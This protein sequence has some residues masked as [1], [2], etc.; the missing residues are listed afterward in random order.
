MLVAYRLPIGLV[1]A[2]AVV[3]AWSQTGRAELSGHYLEARTCQVY[4]GPC[5]ANAE[6]GLAGKDAVMAWN[7]REGQQEGVDLAGLNVVLV[8]QADKTLGFRGLQDAQSMQSVVIVDEKADESQRNALVAF[9]K[10]H[11]GPAGENIAQVDSAPI[12]LRLNIAELSGELTAGK[13]V[14]LGTRK[15]RETDC[16]CSNETA[17]YPPL[18][19]LEH[20][21]PAVTTDGE[22]SARSMGTRWSIPDSRSAYMA[23][24][25]YE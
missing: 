21:A 10:Q 5:F 3:F 22:V 17:Y 8:V 11:A 20:F 18:V 14:K 24:F 16:I 19:Q 9:V 2:L 25:A 4:T 7:I 15:V 6:V 13:A 1:A 12:E 23:T